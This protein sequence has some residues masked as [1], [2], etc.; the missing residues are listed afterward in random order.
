M[1]VY[2]VLFLATCGVIAYDLVMNLIRL[3]SES[4][5]LKAAG[6]TPLTVRNT[7]VVF[8]AAI[9]ETVLVFLI[10]LAFAKVKIPASY[11]DVFLMFIATYLW[12][13]VGAYLTA[14]GMWS[15]FVK[16]DQKKAVQQMKEDKEQATK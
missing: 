16:V 1:T 3:S 15:A 12:K 11:L 5:K 7:I 6:K 14:W 8:V 10:T 4:K 9:V 2:Q 13:N